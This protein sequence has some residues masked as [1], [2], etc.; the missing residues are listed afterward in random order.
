MQGSLED[1]GREKC[2]HAYTKLRE[3]LSPGDIVIT[4]DTGLGFAALKGL[5]GPYM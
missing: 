4:E 1:V 3:D 5:P 2:R